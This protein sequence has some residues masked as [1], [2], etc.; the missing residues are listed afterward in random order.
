VDTR[1]LTLEIFLDHCF[2]LFLEAESLSQT[3]TR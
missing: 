2:T 1:M 3:D